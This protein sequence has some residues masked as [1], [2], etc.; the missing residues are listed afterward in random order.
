MA[1]NSCQFSVG[2]ADG[3]VVT[4]GFDSVFGSQV[5]VPALTML[6]KRPR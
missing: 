1:G 4:G 2:Q 6:L 5:K 3:A